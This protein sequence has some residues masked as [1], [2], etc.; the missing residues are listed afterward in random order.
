MEDVM[1]K[2][3][4]AFLARRE[5]PVVGKLSISEEAILNSPFVISKIEEARRLFR[6]HPFPVKLWG[7]R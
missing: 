2:K 5:K 7:E 3:A 6:E 1:F 4:A